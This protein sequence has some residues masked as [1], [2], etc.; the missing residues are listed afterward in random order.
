[1][2]PE[3]EAI[4]FLKVI[5]KGGHT[6][7]WVVIVQTPEGPKPYVVKLYTTLQIESRNSV[8]AEV[9]GNILA[10]EFDLSAPPAALIHFSQDFI[11]KLGAE[12]QRILEQRDDRIKF[13]S[14]VIEGQYRFEPGITGSKLSKYVELDTLFAFDNFI[15]NGDRGS[16]KPNLLLTRD[17]G[18]VID[19]EMALD[20]SPSTIDDMMAG[21]WEDKFGLH[22]ISHSYL[23]NSS[24]KQKL[25]YFN[26]FEEYLK[27]VNLATLGPYF[28]QLARNGHETNQANVMLYLRSVKTNLATFVTLL[29]DLVK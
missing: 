20:I 16:H 9:V 12:Q 7:P 10:S 3:Y 5:E 6:K 1:M 8:T 4:S 14:L 26:T 17:K 24:K 19:H 13:G 15:R 29:R 28:E 11:M 27:T 18:W 22:H 2:L 21:R 23:K 25:G